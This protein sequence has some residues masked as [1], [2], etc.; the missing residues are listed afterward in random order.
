MGKLSPGLLLIGLAIGFAGC[1]TMREIRIV[2]IPKPKFEGKSPEVALNMVMDS[3]T[4]SAI[5]CGYSSNGTDKEPKQDLWKRAIACRKTPSKG[6]PRGFMLLPKGQSVEDLVRE[7][8]TKA[9]LDAGY[10]VIDIN[11]ATKKTWQVDAIVDRFWTSYKPGNQKSLE[12]W[13]EVELIIKTARQTRA[14]TVGGSSIIT[15]SRIT[16]SHWN[17][18]YRTTFDSFLANTATALQNIWK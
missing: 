15:K 18:L 9:F 1:S 7:L 3:R 10:K 16:N 12:A 6:A 14:I 11:Q 5:N 8:L 4:V 13:L 17:Q 2:D